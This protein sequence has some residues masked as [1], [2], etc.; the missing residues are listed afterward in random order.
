MSWCRCLGVFGPEAYRCHLP[1][2]NAITAFILL[3]VG[4][5]CIIAGTGQMRYN[6]LGLACQSGAV[7][8]SA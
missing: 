4:S 6:V 2:L 1:G 8:V 7:V 5:G 3:M